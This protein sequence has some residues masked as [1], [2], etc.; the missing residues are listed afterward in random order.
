M[1]ETVIQGSALIR[2]SLLNLNEATLISIMDYE[3]CKD[4]VPVIG[5]K[6]WLSS[7]GS[8]PGCADFVYYDGR[9][10]DYGGNVTS[11]DFSVRPAL[12]Y[13]SFRLKKGDRVILGELTFTVICCD[14]MLC[15]TEIGKSC[16]STDKT[17]HRNEYEISDVKKVVQKWFKEKIEPFNMLRYDHY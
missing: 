13:T 12:K 11:C 14:M 15:D 3:C 17:N 9:S 8:C 5:N 16:F 2:D 7:K 10:D 4:I 6:W 1:K